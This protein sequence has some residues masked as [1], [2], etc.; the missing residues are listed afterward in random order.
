M[1]KR[2]LAMLLVIV[3]VMSLCPAIP[4]FAA[5]GQSGPVE[6]VYGFLTENAEIVDG[7]KLSVTMVKVGESTP[8]TYETA[9]ITAHNDLT[10]T[11]YIEM[12]ANECKA[13]SFCELLYQDGV[14]VDVHQ[15]LD[16][17]ASFDR[18]SGEMTEKLGVIGFD[19]AQYGGDLTNE[20][21]MS[22]RMVA[23]GWIY[24]FNSG[25]RTILVG[26]GNHVTDVF[27]E[28]Y[29]LDDDVVIRLIDDSYGT[30]ETIGY[31]EL[32]GYITETDD[33]G[34]IYMTKE[35]Y[36]AVCIFADD[37]KTDYSDSVVEEL[38]IYETPYQQD[39]DYLYVPDDAPNHSD[40]R[41]NNDAF[42]KDHMPESHPE[43]TSAIPFCLMKDRLYWIGDDEV[44]VLL[45]VE[46]K[47]NGEHDLTVMDLGWPPSGYQYMKNIEKLGFDPRDVKTLALTHGHLDHYGAANDF[48]DMVER[49]GGEVKVYES[50]EDTL[51]YGPEFTDDNG[52]MWDIAGALTDDTARYI[53]DEFFP[54]KEWFNINSDGSIRMYAYIN[55]GHS[56]GALSF[57][58]RVEPS[59]DDEFFEEDDVVEFSYMGGYGSVTSLSRGYLRNQFQYSLQYLQSYIVPMMDAEADYIYC[60]PQ[61]TNHY[62]IVEVSKAWRNIN[63]GKEPG[64]DGYVPL[65]ACM[66]E[67]ADTIINQLEKRFASSVYEDYFQAWK[68]DTREIEYAT[69]PLH[70]KTTGSSANNQTNE[71]YGPFKR[72]EGEYVVQVLSDT[73][74]DVGTILHGYNAWQNPSEYF[75][76]LKNIDGE[77]LSKGFVIEKDAYVHDPDHWYVQLCV[78]VMDGYTGNI[79]DGTYTAEDGTEISYSGGPVESLQGDGW[80]EVIRTER[81]DSYEE[82]K[83]LLDT[84]EQ[85]GYYV[86][87]LDKSS[88]I[89][90]ADDPAETFVKTEIPFSDA[91]GHWAEDAIAF[92]YSGGL[93]NGVSG[94][95]FSPDTATTRGMIVTMLYRLEGEPAVTAECPF[96]DVADSAY[97]HDAV[98]W[99]SENGIVNG[100]GET[101]FAPNAN[102]T[103]EQLAAMMYNYAEYKEIDVSASAEL[104]AFADA[105]DISGYAADALAWAVAEG[106]VNG[107]DDENMQPQGTATRAQVATIFQ[108]FTNI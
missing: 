11:D 91:V 3:M 88:E 14:I 104:D 47:G 6:S 74:S 90:I 56:T 80:F 2:Y 41:D 49:A 27:D 10:D 12:L 85:N 30:A 61:H 99:A 106:L 59:A 44:T 25:E 69:D 62:P 63:E 83:A 18:R 79:Q 53:I 4:V 108:R 23:Q 75:K 93:M 65:M 55:N 38:Y 34:D 70:G 57:V 94:Y 48:T 42:N 68:N 51:G 64:D 86:V 71:V 92:A 66:S 96:D 87:N 20:E 100:V 28:T 5:D 77:D 73:S 17:N 76:G 81:L 16:T 46:D 54:E 50:K 97:Y 107:V 31:D 67:G 101:E 9:P 7:S 35:R 102:I 26:D 32:D 37:Y 36:V 98:V 84:I 72:D 95:E 40:Y 89:Q 39:D 19:T 105:G 24:G 60:I 13:G 1:H 58:I 21:G 52:D 22:G 33:N 8:Q 78:H 43:M 15:V 82:A 103:R 29:K 45:M